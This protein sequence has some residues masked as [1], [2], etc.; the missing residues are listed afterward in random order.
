M[1]MTRLFLPLVEVMPAMPLPRRY[2][3]PVSAVR[4]DWITTGMLRLATLSALIVAIGMIPF[5]LSHE[6]AWIVFGTG[7]AVVAVG[8]AVMLGFTHRL[9]ARLAIP[10]A[11]ETFLLALRRTGLPLLGLAFFLAWT[12]VYIGV[13]A[14]HPHTAFVGLSDEPRFADFFYYAVTTGLERPPSDLVAHSR[15]A[16]SATM[17]E[18][19]TAFALLTAYLASFIDWHRREREEPTTTD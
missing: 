4:P 8:A 16:R 10:G 17:I 7:A 9:E 19:L 13:W 1:E 18:M 5:H 12:L 11:S 2:S 3:L 15:G 14:S 6:G